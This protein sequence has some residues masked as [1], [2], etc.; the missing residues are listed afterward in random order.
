MNDYKKLSLPAI[1]VFSIQVCLLAVVE[2]NK[3]LTLW[4]CVYDTPVGISMLISLTVAV[5]C[6]ARAGTE[7]D[8]T[9]A[10]AERK[11]ELENQ[12]ED[13][14]WKSVALLRQYG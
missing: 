5:V 9:V 2:A 8:E 11:E 10:D 6:A 12:K 4:E 1:L 7:A 14:K 3:N 13:K